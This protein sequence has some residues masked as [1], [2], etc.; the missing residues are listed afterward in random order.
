MLSE[1]LFN[2]FVQHLLLHEP[3]VLQVSLFLNYKSDFLECYG[4]YQILPFRSDFAELYELAGSFK[5]GI[6]KVDYFWIFVKP[7]AT[8]LLVVQ[9]CM[10]KQCWG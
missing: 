5:D 3:A 10:K 9:N 8:A 1:D 4:F 6:H 7:D 2:M